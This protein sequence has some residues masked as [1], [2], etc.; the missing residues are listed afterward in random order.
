MG[1]DGLLV[2]TFV[3]GLAVGVVIAVLFAIWAV[4]V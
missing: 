2:L 4:D 3:A 1:D